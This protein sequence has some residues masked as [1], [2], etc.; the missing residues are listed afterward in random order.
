MK[1]Q[2]LFSDIP[3]HI[4]A[5]IVR[6]LV[7][8]EVVRV[9]QIISKGQSTPVDDWYDQSE[10]E[11]VVVIQGAATLLFENGEEI[12]LNPG[13]WVE[14]PAHKKH[15]VTWTTPDEETVWLAVFYR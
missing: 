10:H 3:H 6:E 9:E 5:E 4:P 1:K 13:D 12:S 11:W 14:I 7:S 2:N 15:R 8:T